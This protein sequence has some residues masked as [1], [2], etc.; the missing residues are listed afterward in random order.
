MGRRLNDDNGETPDTIEAILDHPD[1]IVTCSH[2]STNAHT[3]DGRDHG[4]RFYGTAGTM[5]LNRSGYEIEAEMKPPDAPS[6]PTYVDDQRGYGGPA[7][8]PWERPRRSREARFPVVRGDGPGQNLSHIRNF[9]D[10]LK[11]RQQTI[12]D[13]ETGHR[14]SASAILSNIAYRTG[15]KIV[16]DSAKEEIVGD[17]EASKLLDRPDRAPWKT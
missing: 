17:A 1:T 11:S 9:Y 5:F 6:V 15:R 3:P 10:C 4:I 16:W 7:V 13:I 8:P 14:S 12:S 2:R